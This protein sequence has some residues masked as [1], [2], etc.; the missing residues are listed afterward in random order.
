MLTAVEPTRN[1]AQQLD[2]GRSPLLRSAALSHRAHERIRNVVETKR[3][4]L[5]V[6]EA[7]AEDPLHDVTVSAK[8]WR[9]ALQRGRAQ[10]GEPGGVPKG[11]SYAVSPD[12]TVTITDNIENRVYTLTK[13]R[14]SKTRRPSTPSPMDE[15]TAKPK[16][17]AKATK[18]EPPAKEEPA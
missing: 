14:T 12:G 11:S 4:R 17:K 18:A 2:P 6:T 1:V 8:Q 16:A 3:W 7:G 9:T 15:S 5:V 10:I 13:M